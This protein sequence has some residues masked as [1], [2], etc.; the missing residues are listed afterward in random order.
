MVSR[1]NDLP[2][3]EVR[4]LDRSELERVMGGAGPIIIDDGGG[5][6]TCGTYSMCH[7]DGSYE[8]DC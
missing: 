3:F 8:P 4:E 1:K 2:E 6:G 7:I 5:G